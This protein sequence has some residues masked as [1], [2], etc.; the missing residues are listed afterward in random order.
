MKQVDVSQKSKMSRWF[1][2]RQFL[3]YVCEWKISSS[4]WTPTEQENHYKP[5]AGMSLHAPLPQLY[6][7]GIFW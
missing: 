3:Y 5:W 7:F 4:Y 1:R 2:P 6:F